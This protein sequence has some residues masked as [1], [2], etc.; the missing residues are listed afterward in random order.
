MTA[1]TYMHT[2]VC[3][4]NDKLTN[5]TYECHISVFPVRVTI[6]SVFFG[7][8]TVNVTALCSC[9]C[10]NEQVLYGMQDNCVK[11]H[12]YTICV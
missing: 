9:E 3:T 4:Y 10:E 12:L 7:T 5:I 1:H 2:Y 11:D 6:R 8:M